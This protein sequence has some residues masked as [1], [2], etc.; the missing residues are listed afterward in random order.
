[1]KETITTAQLRKQLESLAD[2]RYAR[3]SCALLPQLTR[4][5][6]GVRLPVLR[7]LA[8]ELAK[9]DAAV[10]LDQVV[11]ADTFEE[12]ML[13]GFLIGYAR[14]SW[15]ERWSRIQAF[16]PLIDNWSVC[17]SCCATFKEVRKHREEVWPFLLE[18]IASGEEFRQRFAVVLMM[19]YYLTDDF[20]AP[21]LEKW[22]QLQPAGYYAEMALGWGL[23]VAALHDEASTLS[24]LRDAQVPVTV[25]R[26]ACQK[27][28]ESFRSSTELRNEIKKIKSKL[29]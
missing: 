25:R 7:S 18:Q 10:L 14:F 23:S 1:M 22:R 15:E 27:I 19:D 17:D 5:L 3:F 12:V 6:L 8:H 2:E 21:V 11:S 16:V 20:I 9:Y 26:K 24:L 28:L 4:P 13:R 29:K